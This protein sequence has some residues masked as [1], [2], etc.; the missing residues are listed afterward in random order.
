MLLS[1]S[2]DSYS[3]NL[4]STMQKEYFITVTIEI[5]LEF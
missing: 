4:V 1:E 2:G 3:R 5:C